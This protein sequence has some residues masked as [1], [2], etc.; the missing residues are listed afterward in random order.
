M[1]SADEHLAAM[2]GEG[3]LF[4]ESA[5]N[6][7]ARAAFAAYR[8]YNVRYASR[9]GTNCALRLYAACRRRST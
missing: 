3:L 5:S 8:A 9:P 7:A 2:E 1:K 6:A 4:N